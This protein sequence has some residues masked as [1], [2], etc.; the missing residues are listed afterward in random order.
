MINLDIRQMRYLVTLAETGNFTHAARILYTSQPSLSTFV[1]KVE[2]EL[3]V[4]LFDRSTSPITMTGAGEIYIENLRRI[5]EKAD[6]ADRQIK[7]IIN[8]EIGVL[9]VGFPVERGASMLPYIL[10]VYRQK[11]PNIE[12]KVS[13]VSSQEMIKM[14]EDK[15]LSMGVIPATSATAGLMHSELYEE[16]LFLADGSGAVGR[17]HLIDG[18]PDC[19]DIGKLNGLPLVCLKTS[20]AIRQFQDELFKKHAVKPEITMEVPANSTAYRLVCAGMG[21][22]IIPAL[23][24]N[25]VRE[26]GDV[27]LYRLGR[28]GT[29]WKVLAVSAK[30]RPMSKPENDFIECMRDVFGNSSGLMDVML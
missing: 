28:E 2:A 19:V 20:H 7:D 24:V 11:Y 18:H 13:A 23:T 3:G 9:K 26:I 14:V 17:G 1:S 30:D 16:E 27:R 6:E 15:H 22:A 5:C 8:E 12:V 25:M 4:Q 29:Y 10:P 21:T